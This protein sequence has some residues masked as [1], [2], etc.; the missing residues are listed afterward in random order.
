[1]IERGNT[2]RHELTSRENS[3]NE[4]TEEDV[5]GENEERVESVE[6]ETDEE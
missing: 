3:Y 6:G 1:M 5:D 4:F 2:M